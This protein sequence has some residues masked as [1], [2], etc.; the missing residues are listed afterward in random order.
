MYACWSIKGGS[1]TTV[2]A[3]A[4]AL[5]L[6]EHHGEA[7]VIDMGGDVP[8][9]L[10]MAELAGTGIRDWL[11]STDRDPQ[12]LVDLRVAATS[13]LH[14]I[15]TGSASSFD[16]SALDDLV[17]SVTDQQV[18]VDFGSLQPPDSVRRAA[19]ADWLVVR[20]CYLALRR[21]GRALEEVLE[22]RSL[23][24]VGARLAH[25]LRPRLA[26][27]VAHLGKG[28]RARVFGTVVEGLEGHAQ[29][30]GLRLPAQLAGEVARLG[31]RVFAVA[32]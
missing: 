13:R 21:A 15:P 4:L 25:R 19:R 7:T 14:V 22:G 10:G 5:L 24:R 26:A 32:I 11:S 2:F 8:S 28:Q 12:G 29:L 1:G 3:S 18:V 16:N 9:V 27:L 30:A 17:Q 20:P 31:S 6:A 23:E